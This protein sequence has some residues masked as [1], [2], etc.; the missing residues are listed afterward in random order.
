MATTEQVFVEF[1]VQDQQLDSTTEKLQKAGQLDA[2]SANQFKKTNAELSKRQQLLDNVAQETIS[3]NADV[4]KSIAQLDAQTQQFL[5]DFISGFS[6]GVV[7]AL[8][9]AGVEFNELGEV[10]NKNTNDTTEYIA[11]I[12]ALESELAKLKKSTDDAGDSQNQLDNNFKSIVKR[13]RELKEA[14]QG[15]GQEYLDLAQK[16]AA[17]KKAQSDV[18]K[19]INAFNTDLIPSAISALQGVAGA[20]AVVQGAA[21]LFGKENE[22]LNETLLKVNSIIAI[23]S[24]LEQVN[25]LFKKESAAAT[26]LQVAAQ[27]IYNVVV[28]ETIGLLRVLRIALA[29]TGI[30][31][32]V[33]ALGFLIE[34]MLK[35]SKATKALTDDFR[36]FNLQT[37]HGTD[38]MNKAIAETGRALQENQA[39]LKAHGALQSQLNK[40][41]IADLNS[42]KLALLDSEDAQRDR[43][44]T[45]QAMLTQMATGE[46]EFNEDLADQLQKTVD[47]Y[48]ATQEKRRDISSQIHIKLIEQE[49]QLQQETLEAA[50]D[51]AA[52]RLA[53]ARKNS[54]EEFELAK[55]SARANAALQIFE[56]GENSAKIFEINK[57]LQAQLRALDLQYAQVRQQD[58][59]AAASAALIKVQEKSREI[60]A[61]TSQEEIDAQKKVIQEQTKLELLAEGL[62]ANQIIEIKTKSLDEQLQLQKEFN[63]QS[64]QDALDDQI[65]RNAALLNNVNIAEKDKLQLQEDNL[66]LA[67]QKEIEA[68]EGL[69][70]KIKEIRA[71]LAEDLRTLQIAS[72][73]KRL[74]D[75][76]ALSTAI[77][78]PLRRANERIVANQ[79]LSAKQRIAAQ[80]Q[81]TS[82]IIG[83]INKEEDANEEKYRK[84]LISQSDYNIKSKQLLDQEAQ[85]VEDN[86]VKKRE[87]QKE[88]FE[89]IVQFA[90]DTANQILSISSQLAQQDADERQQNIDAEKQRLQDLEDAGAITQKQALARQKQID[91]EERKL[92]AEQA[93]RDKENALFSAI[94]NTAAAVARVIYNPALAVIVAALGAAQIAVIASKPIPKFGKG[95]KNNYEGYGEIGETGAEL[96]Q[97][98]NEMYLAKSR[99]IVWLGA[100]DRVY[101]PKE[102]IAMMDKGNMQPYIIKDGVDN[103]KNVYQTNIDLDKLGKII[104]SNLPQVGLNI[105]EKGFV[106]WVQKGN[107]LQTYL[108]NRRSY[109]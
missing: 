69:A 77:E 94:I 76:L 36:K 29:A 84:G 35:A 60:N 67:A 78:G 61:R 21:G 98:N 66:I 6:E 72:I 23:L 62:T 75:E 19:E 9:E 12:E 42:T 70:D 88:T 40:Q 54:K 18:S 16:A 65:S 51:T 91:R 10:V 82:L 38:E 50:A 92:K 20:Y 30:G 81:L 90:V 57:N 107:V 108:D 105:N 56:A 49:R 24:G 31:A 53:I 97:H 41:E 27:Q 95:K 89:K 93:K 59:V 109:K 11:R 22:A 74:S 8:Q 86:E 73:D 102:T 32:V 15:G 52:G 100:K 2:Q 96:W 55:E 104:S 79:N 1:V 14:G 83:N 25:A 3:S 47:N 106:Q 13:L 68:N 99:S 44:A 17:L 45:A 46:R 43:A 64:T 80:N 63:K 7:E 85:A 58:R 26:F 33:V 39:D 71:K 34:Y 87:I 103:Y 101:N 37:E 28:G 48:K 4:A 5:K